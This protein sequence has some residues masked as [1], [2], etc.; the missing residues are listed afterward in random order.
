M[1]WKECSV[2][3]ER[4]LNLA[5]K[6]HG[7]LGRRGTN[8][9]LATM[10]SF[11]ESRCAPPTQER[12]QHQPP[13]QD[14]Q[15]YGPVCLVPTFIAALPSARRRPLDCVTIFPQLS[16]YGRDAIEEIHR[17]CRQ[18]RRY[19]HSNG[20]GTTASNHAA[21]SVGSSRGSCCRRDSARVGHSTLHPV[22]SSR[23]A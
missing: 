4:L 14:C 19:V 7:G 22:A 23:Q 13:N 17:T 20:D 8:P 2:M 10:E 9:S 18:V 21:A 6:A 12:V 5:M 16:N 15:R 1:P 3:H 11:D